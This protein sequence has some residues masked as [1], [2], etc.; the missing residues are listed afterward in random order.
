MKNKTFRHKPTGN[1]VEQVPIL[2]IND[3]EEVKQCRCGTWFNEK[4]TALSRKDNTPICSSCGNM[5]A[6]KDLSS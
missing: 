1:I 4:E 5:E 6:I 2:Q 3:Y